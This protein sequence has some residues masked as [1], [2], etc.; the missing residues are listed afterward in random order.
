MCATIRWSGRTDWPSTCQ[1]R[2]STSSVSAIPN[3]DPAS[4]SRRRGDLPDGRQVREHDPARVQRLLGVLHDP[5]G[6]GQVEQDAVEVVD[7]DAVVD[8]ADLD[9]E[10]QVGTE[11]ALDVGLRA[12][13]A[14]S[15]RIS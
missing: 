5:P 14:K 8:V 4:S 10:R 6:L 2:C 3:A 1:V 7:V 12:R 13:R 15:S 9:V 11:E